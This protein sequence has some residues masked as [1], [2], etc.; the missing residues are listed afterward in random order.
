MNTQAV[1]YNTYQEFKV[2]KD[3]NWHLSSLKSNGHLKFLKI[4]LKLL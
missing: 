3:V 4:Y 2:Y 1:T